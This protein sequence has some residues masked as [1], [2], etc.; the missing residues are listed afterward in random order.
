MYHTIEF[1]RDF[2]IDLEVSAKKPLERILIR[3]GIRLS[4]QLK[5]YIVETSQGP[6]EVAD[7][8]FSDGSSTRRVPYGCFAF[9]D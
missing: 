6:A 9:V 4:A 2:V 5:P 7:L 8:F 1:N 3:N